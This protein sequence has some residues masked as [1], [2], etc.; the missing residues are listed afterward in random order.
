MT[1]TIRATLADQR[2]M[3]L[4]FA[5]LLLAL[6]MPLLAATLA[7]GT[8]EA[9]IAANHLRGIQAQYVAE[10]GLEAAFAALRAT[11]A[12][13][14]T[15]PAAPALA[16]VPGLSAPGANL[17]AVGTYTVQYQAAGPNTVLVVA[18]GTTSVG[19]A[20]RRLHAMLARAPLTP[21]HAIL[22]GGNLSFSGNPNITGTCPNVHSNGNLTISGNPDIDGD[23]YASGSYSVSGNPSVAGGTGGGQPYETVPPIVPLD[24]YEAAKSS[25]PAT[26]VF[27]YK[28]D[29]KVYNGAGT[30]IATLGAGDYYQDW[31]F[32]P[33]SPTAWTLSSNSGQ[34]GTYYFEGDVKISGSPGSAAAPWRATILAAGSIEVSGGPTMDD[35]LTDTALVAGK[36]VRISGNPTMQ[37]LV[38]AAEQVQISGNVTLTGAIIAQDASATSG[39]VV[40]DQ[41]NGNSTITCVAINPP[42]LPG[43]LTILSQGR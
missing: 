14:A 27:N 2:G 9:T 17:A 29:G 6:L 34:I 28:P 4:A 43:R 15:A 31:R 19:G 39:T 7:M 36:D 41:V 37:G 33:G 25:L 40:F 26:E 10:A 20:Q 11:P 3:A 32:E 21:E 23:A 42:G 1:T 22:A 5:L 35:H 30:L 24:F 38:G 12:N 13:L 18:T 16:A 8:N